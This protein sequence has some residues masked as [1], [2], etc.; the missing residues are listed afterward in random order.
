T[1]HGYSRSGQ[2]TGT[3]CV[4]Y[5]LE[6]G[7]WIGSCRLS[8]IKEVDY[9]GGMAL[10]ADTKG[11]AGWRGD[12]L[13]N[14]GGV[15]DGLQSVE[16]RGGGAVAVAQ[17]AAGGKG[18]DSGRRQCRAVRIPAV[19]SAA[20]SVGQTAIVLARTEYLAGSAPGPSAAMDYR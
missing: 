8:Q 10:G 7:R 13:A 2:L 12:R 3:R 5:I 4:Q 1:P 6:P 20:Q 11:A 19:G 15:G 14:R 17:A 18:P 9:A 16:S